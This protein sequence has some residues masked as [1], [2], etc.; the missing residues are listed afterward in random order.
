M[1]VAAAA[2][3]FNA[4]IGTSSCTRAEAEMHWCVS[5]VPQTQSLMH[6]LPKAAGG[7]AYARSAERHLGGEVRVNACKRVARSLHAQSADGRSDMAASD[8]TEE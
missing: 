3:S 8:L 5:A 2:G 1:T 4:C 6:C 7:K